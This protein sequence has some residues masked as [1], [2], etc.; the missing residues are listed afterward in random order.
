MDWEEIGSIVLAA[1]A[2]VGGI[3]TVIIFVIK[4]SANTIAD[5]L[6][7]KYSLQLE[8]ELEKYKTNLENKIYISKAKFDTEFSIY[9]ELSK[10]F[11]DMVKNIGIMIPDGLAKYPADKEE[12]EEHERNLYV[13]AQKYTVIAQDTLNANAPFI[14]K[15]FFEQYDEILG[16]CRMQ[17]SVFEERWNIFCFPAEERG[18]L[19]MEDYKRSR[20]IREQFEQLNAVIRDYISKLDVTE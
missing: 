13:E 1:I 6:E 2:S 10:T 14:S 17:L 9:R 15:D 8:K 20:Q 7:K 12:R 3:G 19:E 4:L 5:R 16:L 11:F 18:K